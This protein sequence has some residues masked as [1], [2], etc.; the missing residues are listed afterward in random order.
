MDASLKEQ[1]TD[2]TE[3]MIRLSKQQNGKKRTWSAS[4]L[5]LPIMPALVRPD[6]CIEEA[7]LLRGT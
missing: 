7:C 5:P 4:F 1:Y 3:A 6:A 2:A